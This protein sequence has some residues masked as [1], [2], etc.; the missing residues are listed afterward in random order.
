MQSN[1]TDKLNGWDIW[2][3]CSQTH[4]ITDKILA[5]FVCQQ[6]N[7]ELHKSQNGN[8]DLNFV[9]NVVYFFSFLEHSNNGIIEFENGSKNSST[10]NESNC[11][12]VIL[13][14]FFL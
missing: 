4:P 11:S 9:E 10:P 8:F 2:R 14:A 5:N 1:I 7:R 6:S 12:F 3:R 13:L